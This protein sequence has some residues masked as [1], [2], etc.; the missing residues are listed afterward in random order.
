MPQA[1]RLGAGA[2]SKAILTGDCPTTLPPFD[3]REV[4]PARATGVKLPT[5]E[6]T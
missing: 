6:I 4:N 2:E 3:A 1:A 5:G